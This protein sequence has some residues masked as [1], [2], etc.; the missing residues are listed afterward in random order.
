M[1]HS[2]I[3]ET[4]APVFDPVRLRFRRDGWTPGRQRVF[5]AALAAGNTVAAACD[6]VGL[7]PK[8]AYRLRARADAASFAAAWDAVGTAALAAQLARA[9]ARARAL[10]RPR[11]KVTMRSVERE[12]HLARTVTVTRPDDAG[13]LAQLKRFIRLEKSFSQTGEKN[14]KACF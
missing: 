5:I 14:E 7:A 13:D 2:R 6:L 8:S 11:Y 10:R 1:A 4:A 9:Q 12:G 3:T